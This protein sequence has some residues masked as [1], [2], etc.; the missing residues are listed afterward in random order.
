MAWGCRGLAPDEQE[1]KTKGVEM[2]ANLW[3]G[4]KSF[5]D[6]YNGYC[7]L[8]HLGLSWYRDVLPR[9]GEKRKLEAE[10]IAWLRAE[11]A[12][13]ELPKPLKTEAEV[14]AALGPE[15]EAGWVIW[16]LRYMTQ[17]EGF[18]FEPKFPEDT[19]EARPFIEDKRQ[20]LLAF[21][22]DALERG[23]AINVSL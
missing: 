11:V 3:Y 5:R 18:D 12:A 6:A 14:A 21:L 8:W 7:L 1:Q 23:K 2:G 19:E 16:R 4:R 9:A 13:R 17:S 22:D 10:A 20:R 15:T